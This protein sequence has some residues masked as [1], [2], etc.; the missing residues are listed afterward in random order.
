MIFDARNSSRRWMTVTLGENRVRNVASSIAV[1]PPPTT[2]RSR[3]LKSAPSQVAQADTPYFWNLS[4]DGMPEPLG[5]RAGR[6][7]QRLRHQLALRGDDAERP[8]ADSS[9][10][11]TSAVTHGG[12]EPLRLRLEQLHQLGPFDPLGEARVVLDVGRDHELAARDRERLD[13]GA[14]ALEH[15]R[16]EVGA[17]GVDRGGVTRRS[18]AD[19]GDFAACGKRHSRKIL[20]YLDDRPLAIGFEPARRNHKPDFPPRFSSRRTPRISTPRS[21]P[22]TMS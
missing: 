3:P 18:G 10:D 19:D 1:S 4:S 22:L 15:D 2:A 14:A 16:L 7:D 11:V 21:A 12:A 5:R 20:V 8:V 13:G 9:T 17:G 6:D